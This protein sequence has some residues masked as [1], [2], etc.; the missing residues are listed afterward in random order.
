M[1]DFLFNR[2]K[3]ETITMDDIQ[4]IDGPAVVGSGTAPVAPP[5]PLRRPWARIG[6]LSDLGCQREI[7]EDA[8]VTLVVDFEQDNRRQSIGAF[9]VADGM[10]GHDRGELASQ[11]AARTVLDELMRRLVAPA[12]NGQPAG[13]PLGDAMQ[14]AVLAAHDRVRNE[15]PGSGTTLTAALAIED[16]LAIAHV[17]DSRAYICRDGVVTQATRDHSFVAR[18]VE[19]GQATPEEA[20]VDPR[21]NFLLRAVGQADDLEVDFEFEPFPPGSRLLICSDGL[22][23]HVE[24]GDLERIL[25][26]SDDPQTACQSLIDRANQGGGPDN[27][28]AVIV[29]RS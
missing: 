26:E 16:M 11:T 2:A 6:S 20:A 5:E 9:I 8:L 27:I 24:P 12:M 15:L 25:R 4:G 17:G 28:T 7:N 21:R 22:W 29:M 10:G 14:S 13:G 19:M 1:F 23:G 18:L 3:K